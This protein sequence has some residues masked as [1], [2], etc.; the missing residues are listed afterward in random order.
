MQL[1]RLKD[2]FY[3]QGQPDL[4]TLDYSYNKVPLS[5]FYT[6]EENA[7]TFVRKGTQLEVTISISTSFWVSKQL[8]KNVYLAL[9]NLLDIKYDPNAIFKPNS[10]FKQF[11]EHFS[12][13]PIKTDEKIRYI[14]QKYKLENPDAIYYQRTIPH[15]NKNNGH[16]T[17]QNLKKVKYLL[18]QVYQR[19]KNEDVSIAFTDQKAELKYNND[20]QKIIQSDFT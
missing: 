9:C 13:S 2:T 20:E 14:S 18:P 1:V 3:K 7:L 6:Q 17:T 4:L 5:V 12:Y 10:F 15:K 8:E 16:A 11:D 19:I